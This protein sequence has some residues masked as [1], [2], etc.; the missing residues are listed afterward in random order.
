MLD[1]TVSTTAPVW[2]SS[3]TSLATPSRTGTTGGKCSSGSP[4]RSK[5]SPDT[6]EIPERR[7]AVSSVVGASSVKLTAMRSARPAT[8][9]AATSR[10]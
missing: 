6:S 3:N 2:G 4:P 8:M 1:T 7:Y 10:T 9:A 5:P